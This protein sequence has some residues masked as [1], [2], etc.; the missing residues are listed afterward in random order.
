MSSIKFI[1]IKDENQ[2]N[3][4]SII[5]NKKREILN[6]ITEGNV[7]VNGKKINQDE[8]LGGESTGLPYLYET[9]V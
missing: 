8:N 4:R 1:E 9:L 6:N 5:H 3:R 7:K 2:Y